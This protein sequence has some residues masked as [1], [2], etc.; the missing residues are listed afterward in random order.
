M[1]QWR[2]I[3][4]Q[5]TVG[6][7]SSARNMA[8]DAAILAAVAAGESAPTLRFY[9]W[10]SPCLSLGYG[11]RAREADVDRLVAQGWDMVRRPTGGRAI[12]HADELTYS[13]ALPKNH[14]L[15]QIGVVGSY[16]QISAALLIALEA[17]GAQPHADRA[18][19]TQSV[20]NTPS[21]VC[22]ETPSHYEIT[23]K[24]RKLVGS[25]QVRKREGLLQHGTLPL[26]GDITRICDGLVYPDEAAR[27]QAKSQVRTHA[28]TLA[29]ALGVVIDWQTAAAA[30]ADGFRQAFGV[31]LMLGELSARE[32]EDAER[33]VA[34]TYGSPDWTFRR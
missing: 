6:T 20:L 9:G 8:L 12:L 7:S 22:F 33:F 31:T 27:T 13:V 26:F 17:L 14:S 4:D 1:R 28:L 18:D 23:V 5:P 3:Y 32:C 30:V 2:L 21:P 29:D 34:E 19:S 11:Q 10:L 25:A 15:A 16:R 24:G